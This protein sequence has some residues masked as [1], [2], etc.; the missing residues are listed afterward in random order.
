MNIAI[1]G[2][3][4]VGGAV[5]V[6]L[7]EHGHAVTLAARDL[8]SER[9]QATL[10]R[11][12]GLRA[13]PIADAVAPAELVILATPF[14]AV[15]AALQDAGSL[16]GK[17]LVDATNPVGEG[18]GHALG[19]ELSGGEFVQGVAPRALVVKAFSIYGY[20]NF[21]DPVYPGHGE[22]RPAMLIAGNDLAARATVAD[23]LEELGWQPVETGDI[24]TSLHL[25]HLALL[26]IKLARVQGKGSDFVWAMLTR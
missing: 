18:V 10:A 9:V 16:D 1:I 7:A 19:S 21:E 3:G 5:A 17:I 12:D 23:L 15:K 14:G 11:H 6:K 26:W 20:E 8:A 13:E 22:L 4:K 25:E 24:T 2:A